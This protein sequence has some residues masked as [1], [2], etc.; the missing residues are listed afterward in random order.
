V[1]AAL[2]NLTSGVL[3][4]VGGIGLLAVLSM[5]VFERQKEIGVMRS[6]GGG[7][8]AVITQFLTEGIVVGIIAWLIGLPI[9]FALAPMLIDALPAS[10]TIDFHYPLSVI[11]DRADRRRGVCDSSE[12]V[13]VYL[14]GAQ[15]GFRYFAV[16]VGGK[17]V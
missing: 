11:R 15:D 4:G 17:V 13:A 8:G 9:S 14:G 12:P 5:A 2:F 16:S 1:F 6:I 3:A 10:T 7:S